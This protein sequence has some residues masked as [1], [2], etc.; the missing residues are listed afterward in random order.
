VKHRQQA[1]NVLKLVRNARAFVHDVQVFY[2]EGLERRF[3][4]DR[5]PRDRRAVLPDDHS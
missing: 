2:D 5:A 4:N 1:D 3:L